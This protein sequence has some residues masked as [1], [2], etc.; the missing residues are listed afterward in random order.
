MRQ[1][2]FTERKVK[3]RAVKRRLYLRLA[4][5]LDLD[6]EI[7]YRFYKKLKKVKEDMYNIKIGKR[8]ISTTTFNINIFSDEES[9]KMFRF[10]TKEI[11]KVADLIGF[12]LGRTSRKNYFCSE[13]TA[14]CIVLRILAAPCRWSDLEVIFGMRSYVLSEVFWEDLVLSI[15][16]HGHLLETFRS[17][18]MNNRAQ[19]YADA[20]HNN[21]A[22][23]D[24]CV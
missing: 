12:T 5:E 19:L 17:D 3:K 22:P 13:I 20:I 18:L 10:R 6:E 21:G 1:T 4:I 16:S 15:E 23:L 11:G 24:R 2:D 14:A 7:L 8:G 9:C